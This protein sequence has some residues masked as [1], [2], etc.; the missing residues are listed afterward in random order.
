[1]KD[2]AIRTRKTSSPIIKVNTLPEESTPPVIEVEPR[3]LTAPQPK[4]QNQLVRQG[5]ELLSGLVQLAL[6]WVES[7][8]ERLSKATPRQANAM[9]EA[10]TRNMPHTPASSQVNKENFGHKRRGR[11]GRRRS[12]RRQSKKTQFWS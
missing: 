2:T 11:H 9:T 12:Q 5:L 3:L 4:E 8:E 10:P 1:M 7:R 6:A